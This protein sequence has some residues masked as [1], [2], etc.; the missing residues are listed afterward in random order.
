MKSL[1]RAEVVCWALFALSVGLFAAGYF[2]IRVMKVPQDAA[3]LFG[4]FTAHWTG[5]VLACLL[6]FLLS[7]QPS[8]RR[9]WIGLVLSLLAL[10]SSS[11]GLAC[12][13]ITST[14]TV[15][16][17]THCLFDSKWFF[18]AS[19]VLAAV[20]LVSTLWKKSSLQHTVR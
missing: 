11:W 20:A 16:G 13:H 9:S 19:L 8:Q 2:A 6:A 3:L 10:A 1:H 17:R 12:I 15:N 4:T 14:Q 7:F 18:T 5:A